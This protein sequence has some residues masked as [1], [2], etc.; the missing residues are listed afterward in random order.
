MRKVALN[1]I[2]IDGGT[3]TR[4]EIDQG[5]IYQ[6]LECMKRG[7]VFPKME[8]TFDG[9]SYWL[10]SG[11]HRYHAYK[12]LGVKIVEVDYEL[13]TLQDAILAALKSNNKHGKNL[14]PED[15]EHKVKVALALDG[16]DQ[17]TN[18]EIAKACDLS[19]SFVAGIRDPAK[20]EKQKAA[21]EKHIKKKAKE[22]TEAEAPETTSLTSSEKATPR[23]TPNLNVGANPDA[24]E[25]RANE[26]AFQAD[27]EVMYKLLES[28]EPLKLAHEEI[29]RLN[30]A[31]AQLDTRF[32]GL[33]NEKNQAVKM[34]KQ[35]QNQL[36]KL[37]AKK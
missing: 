32:K 36:D 11:F 17:K 15:K 1:D 30:L 22:L 3:Q 8:T 19:E 7:D 29:K 12:L 18:Y 9:A 25:L 5:L 28:N 24:A 16:Y 6:Y 23:E 33:M 14:T 31:Y 26:I 10:N 4:K 34:V 21:K 27:M 37:K 35:L 13:G 2:R 20:K